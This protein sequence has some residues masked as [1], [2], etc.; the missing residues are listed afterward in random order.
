MTIKT[1][2]GGIMKPVSSNTGILWYAEVGAVDVD[3]IT[4]TVDL[5]TVGLTSAGAVTTDGVTLAEN[6]TDPEV[7]NDWNG[8]AFDSSEATSNPSLSFALLEVLN[9][10]AAKLV[11]EDAA[12]KETDGE[13]TEIT[14]SGNPSN[15]LIVID[16]RIKNRR[17]RAIYPAAS[18]ASRG[19]NV[20]ANDAL[21]S[22]GVTYNLLSDDKGNDRYQKFATIG[23]STG[24]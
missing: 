12:I 9:A 20:Y 18:F 11:Y 6:P 4:A 22:W 7:Y 8:N 16:T 5:A 14:G 13:I 24:E 19:D 1:S 15:K 17:V 2:Q 21:Y 23:A 3:T 10:D